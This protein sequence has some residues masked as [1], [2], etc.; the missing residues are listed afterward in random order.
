MDIHEGL[1]HVP[2]FEPLA[3]E[4]RYTLAGCAREKNVRSGRKIRVFDRQAL[5]SLASGGPVG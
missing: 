3:D 1:R 5:K 2:I 4:Q